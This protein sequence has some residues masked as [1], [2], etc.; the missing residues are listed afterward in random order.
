MS[1][2]STWNSDSTFILGLDVGTTS[3]KAC[4]IDTATKSIAA[5]QS[6][7]TQG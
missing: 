3:V 7:D 4:L 5:I 1:P 6:K 2:S